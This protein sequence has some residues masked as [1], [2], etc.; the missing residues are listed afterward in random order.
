MRHRRFILLVILIAAVIALTSCARPNVPQTHLKAGKAALD[1]GDTATAI[2]ELETVT[3]ADPKLVEARV[4]LAD[5]YEKANRRDDAISQYQA[6]LLLGYQDAGVGYH[7]GALL[8][9]AGKPADATKPLAMGVKL[10]PGMAVSFTK[11]I[12]AAVT[13]GLAAGNARVSAGQSQAAIEQYQAVLAL[14]PKNASAITNLGAA[15]YQAGKLDEAIA[16]YQ[17]ALQLTPDDA[18]T[19]YLLGAAYIQ[20]NQVAKAQSE[21][22]IAL[23]SNP[24]LAPAYIGLGNAQLL[25]ND[26]EGAVSSL[27]K[28]T[29]LAPNS[30]EALYALGKVLMMK[31][32]A[33]GARK[34]FQQFLALNPPQ[35]R[36]A[37]VEQWLKQLGP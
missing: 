29:Q 21:F 6:A 16:Q 31:G 12:S 18:E 23:K 10:N 24:N 9:S 20:Q 36:R 14:A 11:E 2:R 19:H 17:A 35:N 22:Q 27:T 26:L 33:A 37:E 28:A 25:Q 13:A 30:P 34:A 5:A 15:Y 4:L 8:V 32:D 7:L 1:K 3:G